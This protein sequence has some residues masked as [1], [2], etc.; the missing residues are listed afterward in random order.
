MHYLWLFEGGFLL[1]V[2]TAVYRYHAVFSEV[3]KTT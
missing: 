1:K 2:Y 3:A